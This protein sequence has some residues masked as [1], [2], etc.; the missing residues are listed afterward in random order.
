M[1]RIKN[2][3]TSILSAIGAVLFILF[4]IVMW[5]ANIRSCF[6]TDDVDVSSKLKDD[7]QIIEASPNNPIHKKLLDSLTKI[8]SSL[9]LIDETRFDVRIINDSSSLN[10]ASFGNGRYLFWETLADLPEEAIDSIVAHEVAHDMLLHS[11]KLQDLNPTL[12]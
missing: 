10:A 5:S 8:Y 9:D 11:R 12:T 2:A 7:I 4:I 3:I 1:Q 6:T